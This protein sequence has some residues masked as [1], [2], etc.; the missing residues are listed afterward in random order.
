MGKLVD[1]IEHLIEQ[2]TGG[3]PNFLSMGFNECWSFHESVKDYLNELE[4]NLAITFGSKEEKQTCIDQDQLWEVQYYPRTPISF[5]L[6][7]GISLES[8]L[9][10]MLNCLK[11]EEREH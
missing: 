2:I 10:T 8:A 5:H 3:K 6:A 1:K 4:E 11:E 7:G 9:R